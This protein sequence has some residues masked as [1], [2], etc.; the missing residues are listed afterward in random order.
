MVTACNSWQEPGSQISV[1]NKEE[2]KKVQ[3][4]IYHTQETSNQKI[5]RREQEV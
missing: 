5:I 2:V 4:T 1:P 3:A